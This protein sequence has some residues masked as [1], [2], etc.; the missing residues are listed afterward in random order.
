MPNNKQGKICRNKTRFRNKLMSALLP[1]FVVNNFLHSFHVLRTITVEFDAFSVIIAWL[2]KVTS[3]QRAN[4]TRP[5]QKKVSVTVWINLSHRRQCQRLTRLPVPKPNLSL[6]AICVNVGTDTS[7]QESE[8]LFFWHI[9]SFEGQ[10]ETKWSHLTF[11]I[12]KVLNFCTLIITFCIILISVLGVRLRCQYYYR[13]MKSHDN[14]NFMKK[15]TGIRPRKRALT[16]R[17]SSEASTYNSL[18]G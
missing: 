8:Y 3:F 15:P 14:Y 10:T 7:G 17:K 11:G 6:T 1:Y 9:P 16:S 4:Q 13:I 5:T 18:G 2:V 12:A